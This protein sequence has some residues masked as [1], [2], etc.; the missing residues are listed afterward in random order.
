MSLIA[1]SIGQSY[2]ALITNLGLLSLLAWT[3]S[4]F[5]RWRFFL[6]ESVPL[7]R[8]LGIGLVFGLTAA[9]LMLLPFK[10]EQ[11]IFADTRGAPILLS[12]VIG[13]PVAAVVTT[14]AAAAT[15][16]SL[17]G[18]G[19]SGGVIYIFVFGAIGWLTY[20]RRGRIGKPMPSVGMLIALAILAT[21]IS[22]PVVFLLP[23]GKAWYAVVNLW[24][25]IYAA[26]IIGTAVL[27]FLL[28]HE[29]ARTLMEHDLAQSNRDLEQFA[30]VAS[31]DLK[32]PLRGIENLV[33]WLA[34]DLKDSLNDENR[35][36]M[37]MLKGRTDRMEA[38]LEGL[39]EYSRV[40]R[41]HQEPEVVDTGRMV[42]GLLDMALPSTG[43][44]VTVDE[45][46]PVLRTPRVP[47]ELVFRNLIGNALKHHDQEQ[48]EIHIG[49]RDAGWFYEF[50][51]A[52]DGPGIPREF[53]GRLFEIFQTLKPRDEV[54][55]SGMG[56]ALIKRA[57]E[58]HGGRVWME[59]DPDVRRG[60]TFRFTWP[61]QPEKKA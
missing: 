25:Q 28:Q 27:G 12:G 57:V 41:Q 50:S 44:T 15:R 52:D 34:E 32:A 11:G 31:H 30:Y 48:A 3:I 29:A 18:A 51:V 37:E 46:M 53:Q 59:S 6:Q 7:R 43:T 40:G 22:M 4:I 26:N 16:F 56:L 47:L 5:G 45:T 35:R 9:L 61:K 39:L 17:G 49:V 55:G 58:L 33:N 23:E 2:I 42:R 21:L 10:L 60:A 38:L 19:M 13:G 20:H 54:E 1:E 24:P 36:H 14:L 8:A